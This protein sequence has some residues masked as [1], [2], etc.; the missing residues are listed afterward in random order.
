MAI[1]EFD[2]LDD[3]GILAICKNN[4]NVYLILHNQGQE[5]ALCKKQR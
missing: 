1:M 3:S 4:K 5:S 2:R